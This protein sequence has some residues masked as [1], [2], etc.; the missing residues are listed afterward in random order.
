MYSKQNR[1]SVEVFLKKNQFTIHTVLSFFSA[2]GMA[3]VLS[4]TFCL[5]PVFAH[6]SFA[7]DSSYTAG[8][9]NTDIA[10][11]YC[12][13]RKTNLSGSKTLTA[14]GN[15]AESLPNDRFIDLLSLLSSYKSQAICSAVNLH[16][17]FIACVA[18]TR[19]GP[20]LF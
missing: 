5:Q 18:P 3:G 13:A 2:L 4:L 16:C 10:A 7:H 11:V 9:F 20:S 8:L 6:D 1:Y 19:A 15:S 14:S 17:E 12:F